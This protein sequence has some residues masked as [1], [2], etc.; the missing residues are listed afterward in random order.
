MN[1]NMKVK[2]TKQEAEFI[3]SNGGRIEDNWYYFPYYFKEIGENTFEIVDFEKLPDRLK[4]PMNIN[5]PATEFKWTED[6]IREFAEYYRKTQGD[7]SP[8]LWGKDLLEAFKSHHSLPE[9]QVLFTTEDGK[10]IFLGDSYWCVRDSWTIASCNTADYNIAYKVLRFSSQEAAVD[11]VIM[12][13]PI[14]SISDV[15]SVY[16]NDRDFVGTRFLIDGL[17][18]LAQSKITP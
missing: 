13:K 16:S 1:D 2:Y 15:Q 4:Q 14:F 8:E 17:K 5:T 6:K 9:K 12:N 18:I 11:Y 3:R 7:V 10:E